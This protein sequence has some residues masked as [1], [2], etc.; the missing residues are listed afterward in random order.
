M[1]VMRR[2]RTQQ[3]RADAGNPRWFDSRP[4]AAMLSEI[5]EIKVAC[6]IRGRRPHGCDLI[7]VSGCVPLQSLSASLVPDS[8]HSCGG[9]CLTAPVSLV[10][11]PPQ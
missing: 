9:Q 7:P 11:V 5:Q 4:K 2:G 10:H 3:S 1:R 6:M 8:S